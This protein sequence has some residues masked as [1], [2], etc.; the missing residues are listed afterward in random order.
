MALELL[1]ERAGVSLVTEGEEFSNLLRDRQG[2]ARVLLRG[3]VKEPRLRVVVIGAEARGGSA[4]DGE[5]AAEE[6]PEAK[7][8]R[9]GSE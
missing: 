4:A 3:E 6:N 8:R 2:L 5:I 1:N 9:R 7:M